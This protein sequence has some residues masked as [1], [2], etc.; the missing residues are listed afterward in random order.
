MVRLV[1][2]SHAKVSPPPLAST[3]DLIHEVGITMW[4]TKPHVN[5]FFLPSLGDLFFKTK[6][7]NAQHVCRCCHSAVMPSMPELELFTKKKVSEEVKTAGDIRIGKRKEADIY[8]ALE[9]HL[10]FFQ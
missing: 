9:C 8:M 1:S 4:V 5:F 6:A 10:L 3:A 2:F 7:M